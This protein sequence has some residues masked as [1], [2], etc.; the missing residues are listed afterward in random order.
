MIQSGLGLG[1]WDAFH[2]GLHNVTGITVGTA[3][4]LAGL[5]IIVG[6]YPLGVRPGPG[7]LANM[8]LIGA[9]I[10][11]IL[12]RLPV[13][14][15]FV[16]GFVYYAAGIALAG[17]STGM[18]MGA[19]LGNGPRDG[20]MIGVATVTDWPVRRVRAGIELSALLGGWLMGGA[21]GIGTVIF[22][23]TIG[24]A[25]QAGLKM[26]GVLPP[27]RRVRLPAEARG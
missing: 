24:P 17:L 1:P 7:T 5:V 21:I 23:L 9:F 27:P 4:I 22:A 2:V 18:Y 6:S 15:S 14:P 16:M 26:F 3:S 25:V 12:P 8:I 19:R 20:L 13:A 10:D 11:L